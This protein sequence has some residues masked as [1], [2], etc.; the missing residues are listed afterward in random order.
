MTRERATAL[1]LIM[2][3]AIAIYLCYLIMRPFLSVLVWALALAV[4]ALPLH[5]FVSRYI[6]KDGLAAGVSVFLVATVIIIPVLFV[7][8]RLVREAIAGAELIKIE[9]ET[10]HWREVIE[11]NKLTASALHWV[12]SNVDLRA[13]LNR[14]SSNIAAIASSLVTGSVQIL[15]R[16]VLTLFVLFYFFR[17]RQEINRGVRSLLPLSRAEANRLFARIKDTIY[18]TVY[19]TI[20]VSMVQ[21]L[22]GGLMFWWLGLPAPVIWGIIMGLLSMVPVLGAFV[23]WGPA[24]VFLLL[25]GSWIKALILVGWGMTAIGL[26]DNFLY[27]TLVG[28]QIKLHTLLVFFG[29]LGGL[30][31][32]GMSGLILGPVMIA[33]TGAIL[34]I[35]RNRTKDGRT[36]D[37]T[38]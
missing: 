21:G 25:Q 9:V 18:A 30:A 22:L 38:G 17:D 7:G 27:P 14:V 16:L 6:R 4:V 5:K 2:A 10:G 23:I 34:D 15:I 28:R 1:A 31:L 24:A 32:F 20:M 33:S 8:D 35:W 29:V 3:T 26:I 36:L 19:G 13:E 11:S 37:E 12:E